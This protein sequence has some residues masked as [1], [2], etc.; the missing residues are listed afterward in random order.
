LARPGGIFFVVGGAVVGGAV[1]CGAVVGGAVVGGAVVG[2]VVA[3][4]VVGG[5]VVGGGATHVFSAV[6][7]WI[8]GLHMKLAVIVS[9]P[10][11]TPV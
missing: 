4:A 5:A 2:G 3:G 1:L 9:V 10:A 11:F 8:A 7:V 6:A